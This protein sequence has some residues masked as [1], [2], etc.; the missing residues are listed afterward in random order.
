VHPAEALRKCATR[1]RLLSCVLVTSVLCAGVAGGASSQASEASRRRDQ[2]LAHLARGQLA[3]AIEELRAAIALDAQDPTSHDALGVALGDSGQLEAAIV[4]FREAVQLSPD[5][6]D[7]HFH[8]GLVLDRLDRPGEAVGSFARALRLQPQ[9]TEARYGLGLA[10]TKARDAESGAEAATALLRQVTVAAP[11]FA[12]AQYNLGLHLWTRFK[13]SGQGR[14]AERD[15]SLAALQRAVELEPAD[16]RFHSALGQALSE[17]ER[18][19]ESVDHLRRAAALAPHVAE[20]AYNLA[21][22]LRMAGDFNGA[23]E[24]LRAALRLDPR[25]ALAER[26]LGLVLRQLE[27]LQGSA[28]ALRRAIALDPSAALNY[29]LLGTVLQKLGEE[30]AA[31]E[32]YGRSVRLDP[33]LTEAHVNLAQALARSG[34][35]EEAQAERAIVLRLNAARADVGRALVLV[36]QSAAERT[37]GRLPRTVALLREAIVLNPGFAEAHYQLALA[38]A[39]LKDV[40]GARKA[41]ARVVQLEPAHARAH[42]RLA[43]LLRTTDSAGAMR[44]W[45][46]A[47]DAAP[48]FVDAQRALADAAAAAN[49]WPS[50][51]TALE[52]V[53]A[54]EPADARARNLLMRALST[55]G[56]DRPSR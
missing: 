33:E 46:A 11:A 15:A 56:S 47:T 21:L 19:T 5:R 44:E 13:A 48:C 32:A 29:H 55:P 36:G 49:E 54:L 12:E 27:D 42:D 1:A 26:S 8:L 53:V 30:A 52:M 23:A 3:G 25:H 17:R 10:C 9:L 50:A 31:I 14:A 39:D 51:V 7:F 20:H 28:Q 22:A 43:R 6:A 41:F 16:P 4:Q 37:A 45:Q 38:L 35:K 34:R 18:L 40:D 2:G 24:Q